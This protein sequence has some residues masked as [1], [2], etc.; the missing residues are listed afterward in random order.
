M[1]KSPPVLIT[2]ATAGLGRNSARA[3]ARRGVPLLIGGR[4]ADAARELC[5]ELTGEHG[6]DATPF[7]ADLASL[8][9]VRD[10]IDA[11][12]DR[13]LAAI[14]ANA[15]IMT[16][17]DVHSEDGFELTFAVNV[18]AHQLLLSRLVGQLVAGGRVIV[19]S[20]GVH[21]PANK[22]ARRAG[23]PLPRWVGTHHLAL[24]DQAPPDLRLEPGQI[25]YSTS[26]LGNVLQ[27][28]GLQQ[29]LRD[30][31]SDVD[32]FA[33]DPGLMV[34][35][36]FIGGPWV[37]RAL[38]RGIGRLLTPFI[39]NMRLSTTTAETIASLVCDDRWHGRGFQYLDGIDP[40]EPSPDA[41]RDDLVRDLWRGSAELLGSG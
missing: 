6:I 13:P 26:K 22:L 11:L 1:P 23:I 41:L 25:R 34:D 2:G 40:K 27:A 7:I 24:P 19:L 38:M 37:R 16:E 21:D 28:R 35:T 31:G 3:L 33:I 5:A 9:S 17:E 39:G 12:G 20:S 36:D 32:V 30:R 29:R 14:V 4:R 8:S 18:L 15:G 10:A